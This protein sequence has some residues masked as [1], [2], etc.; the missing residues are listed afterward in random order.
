MASAL[1]LRFRW[2]TRRVRRSPS[3]CRNNKRGLSSIG[4]NG[5]S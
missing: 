3:S 5:N 1:T 2:T 4:L